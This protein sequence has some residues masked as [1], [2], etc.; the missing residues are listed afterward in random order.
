[1][2]A[3]GRGRTGRQGA[4]GSPPRTLPA[5]CQPP[6][7]CRAHSPSWAPPVGQRVREPRAPLAGHTCAHTRVE[8]LGCT[9]PAPGGPATPQL[10]TLDHRG[11][12]GSPWALPEAGTRCEEGCAARGT[13]CPRGT[14]GCCTA[15]PL[16]ATAPQVTSAAPCHFGEEKRYLWTP[17][18]M[19]GGGK[20]L[21]MGC[22][23]PPWDQIPLYRLQHPCVD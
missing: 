10:S 18:R 2:A 9:L 8:A 7:L 1:M 13:P 23:T 19:S 6:S 21:W 11:T 22:K 12:L 5:L 20:H 16:T 14:R 17:G 3:W 15:A 4:G